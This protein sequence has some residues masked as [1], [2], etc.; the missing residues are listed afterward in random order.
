M[1]AFGPKKD[2]GPNIKFYESPE[3]VAAFDGIRSWLQ[4]NYKKVSL[5]AFLSQLMGNFFVSN[6]YSEGTVVHKIVF[7]H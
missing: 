2:G 3:T 4:K 5:P 7:S 1:L 6:S